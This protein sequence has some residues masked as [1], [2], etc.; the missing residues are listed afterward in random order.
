[1]EYWVQC[2]ENDEFTKD[3][4]ESLEDKVVENEEVYRAK[5]VEDFGDSKVEGEFEMVNKEEVRKGVK[6]EIEK[7]KEDEVKIE[8]LEE[9]S[10]KEKAKV[11]VG[12]LTSS[13]QP[14]ALTQLDERLL[15]YRKHCLE[16]KF[17]VDG[18]E[19]Q[20][21]IPGRVFRQ[22][23][24]EGTTDVRYYSSKEYPQR[25][26]A[27]TCDIEAS[28][29]FPV[30]QPWSKDCV[31]VL[32]FVTNNTRNITLDWTCNYFLRNALKIDNKGNRDARDEIYKWLKVVCSTHKLP[33]AQMWVPC[34]H[35]RTVADDGSMDNSSDTFDTSSMGKVLHFQRAASY[36]QDNSNPTAKFLGICTLNNLQKGQGIVGRA[37]LSRKLCFCRDITQFSLSEYPFL[38]E[39]RR[40]GLVGC[41]TICLQNTCTRHDDFVL[42]F[43]L[44]HE[45]TC[46]EDP[47]TFFCSILKTMK[48]HF[49]R[50]KLASGEELEKGLSI[51]VIKPCMNQEPAS[52]Q[53]PSTRSPSR[54]GGLQNGQETMQPHSSNQQLMLEDDDI[55]N[56]RIV[57]NAQQNNTPAS[58]LD[59]ANSITYEELKKHFG[60][61]LE[62]VAQIFGVSRSTF[63]RKCRENKI[64]RW[65][66]GK[67]NKISCSPSRP[68]VPCSDLLAKKLVA[69]V[70]H[71]TIK[72]K[73][74]DYVIKF[75]LPLT[76]RIVELEENVFKRLKL[77]VGTYNITYNDGDDQV[78]QNVLMKS[79]E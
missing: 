17:I 24:Q 37:Y 29:A 20:L 50:F 36:G 22:K 62:D 72:A 47:S 13:D 54:S 75:Q 14:F 7:V 53:C 41:F 51:E 43:F 10:A 55:S 42:E 23:S 46:D 8:D 59:E 74:G 70:A 2:F 67:R 60:K 39:A 28:V 45:I 38:P 26:F 1:M 11:Q 9:G 12:E 30:F 61:K 78:I 27:I 34:R 77:D 68:D 16:C 18:D 25:N 52:F 49:P 66:Q 3:D 64:H 32:E 76:S 79:K 5:E 48:Q 44:H 40:F 4:Y 63:K 31:G 33:S 71:M 69:T 58:C 15:G 19:E 56:G 57:V 73:Y 21:G 35:H 6:E 65:P